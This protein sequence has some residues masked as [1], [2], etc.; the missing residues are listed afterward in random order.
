[1]KQTIASNVAI[2]AVISMSLALFTPRLNGSV[3][4]A[5]F[6]PARPG[7][8]LTFPK[9]HGKHPTYKTEWW[10]FTGN[11]DGPKSEKFGFQ[12][13]FFRVGLIPGVKSGASSWALTELFPAH[14]AI[15]NITERT[16]FHTD[17]MSRP[18]PGLAWAATDG[19]DVGVKNWT[20]K[21]DGDVITVKAEKDNFSIDFTLTALKPVALHGDKGFSKKA[22]DVNQASYYYSFTR[23]AAKGTLVYAGKSFPVTGLAWMDHEFGSGVLASSQSGWDWFSLQLEDGTEV[24]L[25]YLRNA[26]GGMEQPFGSFVAK[27]GSVVDLAGK[28]VRVTKTGYWKSPHTQAEYPSGWRIEIP[29]L[30]IDLTIKPALLDQEL[31]TSKSTGVVYWEGAIS[32]DGNV[33]GKPVSGRGYVE[34]TGYAAS[35]GGLF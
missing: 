14:F 23:L 27:D 34:L 1:M 13:T 20:A 7:L 17:L 35:L 9:D 32:A 25:S 28:D 12:L 6:E 16:F 4:A 29:D 31:V 24:M 2:C 10:Y 11:V 22:G 5:Q 3:S 30:E 15:S 18:G 8:N 33:K 26:G 19:L 21:M